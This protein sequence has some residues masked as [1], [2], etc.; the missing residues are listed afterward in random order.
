[1]QTQNRK[2]RE[3]ENG[4]KKEKGKQN[5]MPKQ[6]SVNVKSITGERERERERESCCKFRRKNPSK[7]GKE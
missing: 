3:K 2:K 7:P 1:M 4:K 5:T 6:N